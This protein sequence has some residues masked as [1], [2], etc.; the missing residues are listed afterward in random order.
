MIL[1]DTTVMLTQAEFDELPH[2]S[3]SLP[4][5][6]TVGKRWKRKVYDLPQY[7][8]RWQMGEYVELDPPQEGQVGIK[9]R[10]IEV[11]TLDVMDKLAMCEWCGGTGI[12][13]RLSPSLGVACRKCIAGEQ[14][15]R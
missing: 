10:N 9:W 5:L 3:L 4:T 6:T 1:D 12:E 2:Y 13:R 11:G 7:K 8:Y 14:E 15:V